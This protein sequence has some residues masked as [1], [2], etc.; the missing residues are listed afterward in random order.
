M[1]A[2]DTQ[3]TEELNRCRLVLIASA[4]TCTS[5]ALEQAFEGGDIASLIIMAG[6]AD[7]TAFAANAK[8]WVALAQAKEVATLI[9]ADT[10]IAGRSDA[11]GFF[12]EKGG[13]E[14]LD[15]AMASFSPQKIVGCGG[16]KDRHRALEAGDRRPDFVFFGKLNGDIKPVPHHKNLALA[17]WWSKLIETPCMIMGGNE[18]GS[19]IECAA[20]GADFVA[21]NIAVFGHADGPKD[22]VSYA[23][24]LLDDNAPQFEEAA[25]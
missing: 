2:S 22:A 11:D 7:S 21:L 23:N 17:D 3:N 10:Q 12:I 6:E 20:S 24:H 13:M 18:I 25:G 1:N 16:L 5:A 19:V 4:S 15:E 8:E 9:A 14:A